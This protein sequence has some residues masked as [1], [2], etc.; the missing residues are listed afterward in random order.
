M[1]TPASQSLTLNKNC[2]FKDKYIVLFIY[3]VTQ[4]YIFDLSR[5]LNVP[6]P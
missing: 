4:I 5:L 2:P 1:D 3:S 6:K